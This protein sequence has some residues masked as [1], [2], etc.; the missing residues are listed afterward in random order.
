MKCQKKVRVVLGLL[1]HIRKAEINSIQFE[2]NF[3]CIAP[4]RSSSNLKMQLNEVI[5]PISMS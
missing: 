1:I 4:N 2:F 3:I 5:T